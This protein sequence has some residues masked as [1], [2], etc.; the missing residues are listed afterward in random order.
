MVKFGHAQVTRYTRNRPT[1]LSDAEKGRAYAIWRSRRF[2]PRASSAQTI[3]DLLA[4]EGITA[5]KSTVSKLIRTFLQRSP[6]GS[7]V[8]AYGVGCLLPY[9]TFYPFWWLRLRWVCTVP[10]Y[11]LSFSLRPPPRSPTV[12]QFLHSPIQILIDH[13]GKRLEATLR[14]D[15]IIFLSQFLNNPNWS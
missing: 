13:H 1:K 4:L 5:K 8:G 9:P 12:R 3:S 7:P 15:L 6:P 2:N 10:S 14:S 11:R